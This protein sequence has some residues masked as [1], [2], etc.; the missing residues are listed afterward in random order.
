MAVI[1]GCLPLVDLLLSIATKSGKRQKLSPTPA[2]MPTNSDRCSRGTSRLCVSRGINSAQPASAKRLHKNMAKVSRQYRLI[3]LDDASARVPAR[4]FQNHKRATGRKKVL[5]PLRRNV[6]EV[7]GR[8]VAPIS[9]F[10]SQWRP[11]LQSGRNFPALARARPAFPHELNTGVTRGIAADTPIRHRS[12]CEG[13]DRHRATG[14]H[15]ISGTRSAAGK[16]GNWGPS[17][18]GN[19]RCRAT[20]QFIAP[21]GVRILAWQSG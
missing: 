21:C 14:C 2:T 6:I 11:G 15:C 16:S 3:V 8:V 20:S 7:I 19:S 12:E 1:L 18:S 9:T 10:Q 4:V 17:Q 13:S 5:S